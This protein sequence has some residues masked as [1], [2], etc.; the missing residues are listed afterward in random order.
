MLTETWADQFTDL[1]VKGFSHFHINRSQ[2][3]A[4]T[5]RASVGIVIYI[6][7]DMVISDKTFCTHREYDDA[8][9]IRI[10]GT[11]LNL[12][13]DIYICLC[14]NLPSDSSRQSLVDEELFDRICNYVN[15]LKNATEKKRYFMIC[16]DMNARI[17]DKDDFVPL[18]ISTHIDALPEDYV[19]DTNLTRA[20]QDKICNANGSLLLDLCRKLD[21]E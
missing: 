13:G 1:T 10:E 12:D 14:Y 6:R 15:S 4:N 8:I 7:E 2:Y 18:D 11:K 21:F 19:C 17:S 3:K 20:T 5:K 16:G 9:W